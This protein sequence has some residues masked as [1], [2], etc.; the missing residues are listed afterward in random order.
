MSAK[1]PRK[2]RIAV[3]T[4]TRAEYGLLRSSMEAISAHPDLALRTVVTGMH[5]LRKFGATVR[6]IERDGWRINA[7]VSM[8]RGDDSPL[9]QANG[10]ARGIK[11]I[12]AYLHDARVDIVLL[13]GDRIEAMAGALAATT[14]GRFIAHVH[15]GDVAP[16][17][18]D[19][20]LRHG[21]TKLAHIHLPATRDAGR[22]LIRMGER[23]DCVHVVGAPGLDQLVAMTRKKPPAIDSDVA[24]VVHHAC[25]RSPTVEARSM[26]AVLRAVRSQG[27]HAHVLYPNSDRGHSGI[28]A[29]I[30]RA[31][32]RAN[33]GNRLRVIPSMN[34]DEY[35]RY[36]I[37]ARVLV[38]NSS[39]GIIEA[40]TAG[41]PSVNVGPRQAGRLR[42]GPSV[43][44][45]RETFSDIR[46][47][48]GT[49][50]KR[51]PKT[52]HAT[53]YG[54]GH[55]GRRIA[56]ILASTP[57]DTFLLRKSTAL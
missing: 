39:S 3:V 33:G 13:L 38:G 6:H 32:Q 27:L 51:R 11:G 42:G 56:D 40:P 48:L 15:G 57:L 52:L 36:L 25:G 31:R 29:A 9:D 37:D 55:A 43:V 22:R 20:A 12:A 8:Q 54:D 4:G 28:I 34:R 44:D 47:A 2:R 18:M 1:R 23:V 21:I 17:D 49:A 24:L 16:G 46:D 26:S 30:N 7:R 5:L 35:L 10:L 53:P 50:T 41:T 14:T 45:A 19:E